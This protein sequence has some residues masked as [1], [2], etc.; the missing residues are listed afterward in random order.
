MTDRQIV[1]L[2]VTTRID[3]LLSAVG[4]VAGLQVVDIGCGEGQLARALAAR[5]A[6]VTGFDPFAEGTERIAE[7]DGSYRLV[8]ASADAI[9]E[10][11]GSAD[12]VVFM[13]SLH[14]VPAATLPGALAEARRLLKPGGRLLVAEPIAEGPGQYVMEPYH[15]ET[16][17]RASAL[18]ALDRHAAPRFGS[19][20][21]LLFSES[22]AFPSFDAYA[23]QAIRNMA[24]NGYTEAE[25]LAPEVRRRF[26]AMSAAHGGRLDQPVRINLFAEP[27]ATA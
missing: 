12:L 6:V 18:A 11:S 3:A 21:V 22:R 23:V 15:D 8:K 19:Q 1:D 5:G 14:H 17:V 7:G 24:F 25:V 16:A 9:P 27:K 26:E 20:Q 10:P 4:P 13:F 2:G